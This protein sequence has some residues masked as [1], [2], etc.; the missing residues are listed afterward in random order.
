LGEQPYESSQRNSGQAGITSNGWVTILCQHPRVVYSMQQNQLVS[1]IPTTLAIVTVS[2]VQALSVVCQPQVS[3]VVIQQPLVSSTQ[4]QLLI[5]GSLTEVTQAQMGTITP[6]LGQ[7]SSI[8]QQQMVS[9]P[10]LVQYQ[11][12]QFQQAY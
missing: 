10:W 3:Q 5:S 12:P 7:T 6:H 8:G 9:Q 11:Q 2:Q 4:S 1:N